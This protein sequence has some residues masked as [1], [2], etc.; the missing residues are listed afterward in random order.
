MKIRKAALKDLDAIASLYLELV[1]FSKKVS[2]YID[3]TGIINKKTIKRTIKSYL[4]SPKY[5]IVL[6]A[7]RDKKI[8]GFVQ[9]T[10]PTYRI[11]K[12]KVAEVIGIYV[13]EKRKGIGKMLLQKVTEWA[14]ERN[15]KFILWE[16]FSKNKIA[17]NFLIKNKF[18]E[19]KVKMLKEL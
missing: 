19:F 12:E 16:P 8:I 1:K 14:K 10:I 4:R 15:A 3:S 11:N 5:S 2:K 17:T 18:K 6:V 13:S 7:E 9:A